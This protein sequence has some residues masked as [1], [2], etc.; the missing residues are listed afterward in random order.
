MIIAQ[1]FVAKLE[2]P[3]ALLGKFTLAEKAPAATC[4]RRPRDAVAHH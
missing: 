4:P 3:F 2:K 1:R